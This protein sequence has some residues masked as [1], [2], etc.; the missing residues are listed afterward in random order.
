MTNSLESLRPTSLGTGDIGGPHDDP[1]D[2]TEAGEVDRAHRPVGARKSREHVSGRNPQVT[3][4]SSVFP[5]SQVG[6]D[7]QDGNYVAVNRGTKER[8]RI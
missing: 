1:I 6:K 3:S 5:K 4:N 7:Q 8:G 2:R